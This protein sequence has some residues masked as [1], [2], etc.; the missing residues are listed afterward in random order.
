MSYNA[1]LYI[2]YCVLYALCY[3]LCAFLTRIDSREYRL[4]SKV[5]YDTLCSNTVLFT[6]LDDILR[7]D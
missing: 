3:T 4:D 1:L 5:H 7:N 2:I 6:Y